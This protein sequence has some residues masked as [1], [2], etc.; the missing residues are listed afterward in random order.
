MKLHLAT[1]RCGRYGWV[2]AECS[3]WKAF[4]RTVAGDCNVSFHSIGAWHSSS[5][6]ARIDSAP[7]DCP[8]QVWDF[9]PGA[10]R[11]RAAPPTAGTGHGTGYAVPL[12][13]ACSLV[14]SGSV[15]RRT[16]AFSADRLTRRECPATGRA[17][18][19]LFHSQRGSS[20]KVELEPRGPSPAG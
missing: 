7:S 3:W 16:D 13:V 4:S 2:A 17:A 10:G 1:V 9:S 8:S 11:H 15:V 6:L 5:G 18:R 14:S 19:R 12:A 20:L